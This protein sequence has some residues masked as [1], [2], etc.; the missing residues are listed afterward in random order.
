MACGSCKHNKVGMCSI[1]NKKADSF[2]F[3]GAYKPDNKSK[4]TN[5]IKCSNCEYQEYCSTLIKAGMPCTG[6]TAVKSH[7]C[8]NCQNEVKCKYLLKKT[9]PDIFCYKYQQFIP[10][11]LTKKVEVFSTTLSDCSKCVCKDKKKNRCLIK[12]HFLNFYDNPTSCKYFVEAKIYYE[13]EDIKKTSGVYNIPGK[14]V[15]A[16]SPPEKIVNNSK[17]IQKKLDKMFNNTPLK[18]EKEVPKTYNRF[19]MMDFDE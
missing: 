13:E 11:F 1:F 16:P 5:L 8:T 14:W 10:D 12:G 19:E 3:C 17:K 18:K 2:S 6:W 4:S 7:N 15:D 9:S